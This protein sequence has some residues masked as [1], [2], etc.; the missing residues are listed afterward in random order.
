M[1]FDKTMSDDGEASTPQVHRWIGIVGLFI[2]PTTIITSVCVYF[3][4]VYT[5]KF[6]SYFGIESN[7][8]GFTSSDHVTASISVLYAPILV[9]LLAW[10]AL[11]WAGGY[12][13]RLVQAGRRTG[14]IRRLAWAAIIVGA[15]GVLRGVVGV[16]R[17]QLAVIRSP[18]LT[19]L[20]LGLGTLLVIVGCWLL[21]TLRT[22]CRRCQSSTGRFGVSRSRSASRPFAAAE[23]ASLFVAAAM[24]LM[25]LFWLTNLFANAYGE[26]EAQKAAAKLW[27]KETSVILETTERLDPPPALIKRSALGSTATPDGSTQAET[28]ELV[29]YRYECF[30]PLVVRG[31]QWVLV[32]AK[33]TPQLGYAVIVTD[34]SS[35]RI[36]VTQRKGIAR[37]GAVN[38]KASNGP[39]GWQCPEVAPRSAYALPPK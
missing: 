9:L 7:A 8:I 10:V 21:S 17:P 20:A 24:I 35:N 13:R 31:D 19:P 23:R 29:T 18:L 27:T 6:Y 39:G 30:R 32:P 25:A 11:L 1:S 16:L 34:D 36:S 22:A 5:R 12:A 33:W 4:L 38:W 37:T 2:A 15:L 14:L 3:G 28:S 26:Q